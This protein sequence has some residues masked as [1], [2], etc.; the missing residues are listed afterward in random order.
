VCLYEL[1]RERGGGANPATDQTR[2]ASA[3]PATAA[4]LELLT[5]LLTEVMEA[6]EYTRRHAHNCDPAQIRR[7]VRRMG[8]D[9]IDAPVWIGIF[10][11]VLWRL[12]LEPGEP[13]GD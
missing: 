7:L 12:G 9:A 3:D 13:R 4:Q 2:Q 11:Q 1:V 6:T 8:A 10:K 5:S